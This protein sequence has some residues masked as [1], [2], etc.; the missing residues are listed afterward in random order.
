VDAVPQEEE[1]WATV[2]RPD[3]AVKMTT[4]YEEYFEAMRPVDRAICF[5]IAMLHEQL[6]ADVNNAVA[7][8]A[9]AS[10]GKVVGFMSV[11]ADDPNALGEME[12]AYHELG[13]RGLKLGPN[14]QNFDPVGENACRVYAKAQEMGLPVVFHQGTSPVRDAPIRYAHPLVM[15]EIAIR[16]PDLKIVMA[17]LAHPWLEDC[18]VVVRK[19]PNVYADVSA[20][21]YRPWSFYNGMR[22]AYEWAVMDKLLFGTDYPVSTP[23][24]NMNGLRGLNGFARKHHLPE[25]PQEL[26]EGIIHRD[27]LTLLGLS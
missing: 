5:G 3:R 22:Y 2:N 4:S 10:N 7:A 20:R 14:Y 17:H 19:H 23:Q 12:R 13:L 11:H 18:L 16:F 25:V 6:A 21:Y 24:E 9:A 1:R 15:D 27:T 8:L 26:L